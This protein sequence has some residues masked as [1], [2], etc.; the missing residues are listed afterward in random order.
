MDLTYKNFLSDMDDRGFYRTILSEHYN[1]T[2]TYAGDALAGL[3]YLNNFH[4]PILVSKDPNCVAF[5]T[6]YGVTGWG[7]TITY[8][9]ETWYQSG[10]SYFAENKFGHSST[11]PYLGACSVEEVGLKLL[12]L[13]FEE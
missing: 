8:N 4:G 10:T 2:K 11:F 5:S 7:S 6:M 1:W 9:G 12:K 3:F 13:A